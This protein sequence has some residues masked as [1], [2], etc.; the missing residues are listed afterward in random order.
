MKKIVVLFLLISFCVASYGQVHKIISGDKRYM[1]CYNKGYMG[2][3]CHTKD[4]LADGKWIVYYD[5]AMTK[6]EYILHYKDGE[7]NGI[8]FWYSKDG[9]NARL[10][11][12]KNGLFNGEHRDYHENGQLE[13]KGFYYNHKPIG[14]YVEYDSIGNIIRYDTSPIPK[15]VSYR[16]PFI[17]ENSVNKDF[18]LNNPLSFQNV[19]N[20]YLDSLEKNT[21]YLFCN[22]TK[23]QYFIAYLNENKEFSCFEIG[24]IKSLA[25]K[26]PCLK[27]NYPVFQRK[28]GLNW[29]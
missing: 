9:T 11:V 21:S 26:E 18:I 17:Q 19:S 28:A 20:T 10:L 24:Y 27:L 12:Y 29:V 23:N 7:K 8:F 1:I 2:I 4:S 14:E 13:S 22:S 5:S 6:I 3:H 16:K 15:G 25:L